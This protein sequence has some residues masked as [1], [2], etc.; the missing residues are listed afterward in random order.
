ML[1]GKLETRWVRKDKKPP[2]PLG[3]YLMYSTKS[4]C[5]PSTLYQWCGPETALKIELLLSKEITRTF[6][7][8]AIA[9]GDLVNVRL[10]TKEDE[11]R[12]F[13]KFIGEQ[14][15][16]DKSGTYTRVQWI[17]EFENVERIEQPYHFT[18]GKQG[19][20]ILRSG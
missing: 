17:L 5:A 18:E 4:S 16:T 11:D 15:V 12:A 3:K 20:G 13:V 19:V 10:M 7:G 8:M 9:Y 1:Y 6:N 14:Q 2:F